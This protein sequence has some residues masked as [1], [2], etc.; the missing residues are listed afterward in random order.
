LR[1]YYDILGVKEDASPAE[2][3]KAYR[4]KASK[5]HPD[6]HDGD[7]F[8]SEE[9]KIVKL[10]YD[11]LSDPQKREIY[12]RNIGNKNAPNKQSC[13]GD[14][15][16]KYEPKSTQIN[17]IIHDTRIVS[18]RINYELIFIIA[19]IIL[20]I[21]SLYL[22]A[23]SPSRWNEIAI[24]HDET[25]WYNNY[26]HEFTLNTPVELVLEDIDYEVH[27]PGYT[28]RINTIEN[29]SYELGNGVV[30][31]L[32]MDTKYRDFNTQRSAIHSIENITNKIGGEIISYECNEINNNLIDTECHFDIYAKETSI[33]AESYSLWYNKR[34]YSIG[35]IRD[36]TATDSLRSYKILRS[37]RIGGKSIY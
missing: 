10:A 8:F 28:E 22:G 7:L 2:I 12:D 33:A 21:I 1:T 11:I 6:K 36:T 14:P 4:Y 23:N 29:Y 16:P 20:G 25:V 9:F 17:T 3:K 24:T 18:Y 27:F 19:I 5:L 32:Y 13:G 31:F 26:I 35:L 15:E 34:V 37:M 30:F